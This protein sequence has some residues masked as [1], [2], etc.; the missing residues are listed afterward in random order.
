MRASIV[1]ATMRSQPAP[2]TA[3]FAW[4]CRLGLLVVYLYDYGPVDRLALAQAIRCSAAGGDSA[5][6]FDRNGRVGSI[7]GHRD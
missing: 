5:R 7:G 2:R 1:I 3:Y 4:R 6:C